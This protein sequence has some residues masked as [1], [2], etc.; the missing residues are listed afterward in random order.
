MKKFHLPWVLH[1]LD[2]SQKVERVTLPYR[3]LLVLQSIRSTGF[4]SVI[5]GDESQFFLYDPG[6]PIWAS[7]RDEVPESSSQKLTQNNV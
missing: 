3:I 2:T 5:T 6:D 1:A 4:Q 7:S